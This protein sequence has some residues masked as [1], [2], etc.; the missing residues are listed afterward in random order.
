M[1]HPG[2]AVGLS[3]GATVGMSGVQPVHATR[4]CL[5]HTYAKLGIA[6]RG[7]L[8]GRIGIVADTRLSALPDLIRCRAH[9]PFEAQNTIRL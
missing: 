8:G 9:L 4:S 7:Y 1:T 2:N 5:M 6:F 3:R